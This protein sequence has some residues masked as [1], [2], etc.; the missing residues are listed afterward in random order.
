MGV[1]CNDKSQSEPTEAR[2][3]DNLAPEAATSENKEPQPSPSNRSVQKNQQSNIELNG[4]K[5]TRSHNCNLGETKRKDIETPPLSEADKEV[6][7]LQEKVLR[8][9]EKIAKLQHKVA[10]LQGLHV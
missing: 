7:R 2:A 6:L 5:A 8:L 10:E 1:N 3:N 9:Q 4:S